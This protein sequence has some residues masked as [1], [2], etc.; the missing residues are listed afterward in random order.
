[1]IY[2]KNNIS[3]F[4]IHVNLLYRMFNPAHSIFYRKKRFFSYR[5]Q[6][7]IPIFLKIFIA[8][9]AHLDSVDKHSTMK[10]SEHLHIKKYQKM[11][12]ER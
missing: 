1:M 8:R 10:E 2:L 5:H 9:F 6:N 7:Y 3:H 4:N 12:S 11:K